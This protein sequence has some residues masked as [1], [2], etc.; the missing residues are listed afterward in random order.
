MDIQVRV[1]ATFTVTKIADGPLWQ[2]HRYTE[3]GSETIGPFG[4]A[5][6]ATKYA[7][8]N[9]LPFYELD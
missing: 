5:S 4:T 6:H 3:L 9:N 8:E 2:L 7:V 1:T